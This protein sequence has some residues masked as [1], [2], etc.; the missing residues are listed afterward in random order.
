MHNIKKYVKIRITV[1]TFNTALKMKFILVTMI[2]VIV[3]RL[4][5]PFQLKR[6]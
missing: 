2:I 3:V 1:L 6:A 5:K 4:F